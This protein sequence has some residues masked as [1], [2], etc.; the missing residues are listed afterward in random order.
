[1]GPDWYYYGFRY[2]DPVTGRWPSRDPIEEQ[3]GLN[4]YAM[5]GNDAVNDY[6]ILGQKKPCSDYSKTRGSGSSA[7]GRTKNQK[8]K[9]KSNGCGS[10]ITRFIVPDRANLFADFGPACDAH[11]KCY[12]RCG[13]SQAGCDSAF[14]T[15]MEAQC[16]S[17]WLTSFRID[18]LA[19]AR[20]YHQAV[21]RFGKTAHENAQDKFCE[22]EDCCDN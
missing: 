18:C 17:W 19:K 6:D 7:E 22:W 9:P 5:V 10:G 2:Y 4:L 21:V 14:K 1:M 11:D 13:S 8:M 3:G 15:D 16:P 12:S 20:I